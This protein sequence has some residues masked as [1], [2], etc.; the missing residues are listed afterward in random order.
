MVTQW[1]EVQIDNVLAEAL[2]D[3]LVVAHCDGNPHCVKP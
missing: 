1:I 2:I 3:K